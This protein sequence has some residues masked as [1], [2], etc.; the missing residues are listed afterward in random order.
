MVAGRG[1]SDSTGRAKVRTSSG[2]AYTR[3]Q[4]GRLYME[5]QHAGD[6]ELALQEFEA[7]I[8]LD[9]GFADAYAGKADARIFRYWDTGSH[10]DIAQARL[11]AEKAISLDADN[12]YA[13]TLLCRIRGRTDWDLQGAETEC[14]RAVE[15]DPRD[16]EA[17][18][19][20][21]FLLNALGRG[22][23]A[24]QEMDAAIAL[25]PSSFNKRSRGTLLYYS[26]R[27]DEAIEQLKQVQATDPEFQQISQ[28]IARCYELKGDYPQA[29]EF[30]IRSR[31]SNSSGSSPG[32]DAAFRAAFE[33]GGWP[34]VLRAS[35]PPGRLPSEPR[36]CRY[37]G[38]IGRKRPGL[39]GVGR[40]D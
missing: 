6:Y 29:L 30:L 1:F 15:L 3:Y 18:R 39:R 21:A 27:Y 12:S 16:H 2:A 40:D 4:A 10:D 31:G 19:E 38:T 8:E 13:H 24:M 33:S 34:A 32:P 36:D 5:R 7:A 35:L 20:Y 22:D 25:A 37:A 11:A 23:E 17:R 9:P 14:R 26:R 28:W